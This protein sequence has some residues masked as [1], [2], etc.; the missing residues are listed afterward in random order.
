M[1]TENNKQ[2][3]ND[4]QSSVRTTASMG[5]K[6]Y[7]SP[8]LTIYGDLRDLTL[9]PSPGPFESGSPGLPYNRKRMA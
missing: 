7:S 5:R 4:S 1:H 2:P 3:T 9:A 6:A 8:R